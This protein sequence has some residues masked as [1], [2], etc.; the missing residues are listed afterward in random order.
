MT[1]LDELIT[2]LCPE[3]VDFL[4]LKLVCDISKGV[5]FIMVPLSRPLSQILS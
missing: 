1:K 4:P 5:Q 3:G 2:E